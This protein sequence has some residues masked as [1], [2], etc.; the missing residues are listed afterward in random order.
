[1]QWPIGEESGVSFYGF[2]GIPMLNSSSQ[3]GED[4]TV[5]WEESIIETSHNTYLGKIAFIDND[6]WNI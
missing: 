5:L 6:F 4:I 2:D 1:L 3:E